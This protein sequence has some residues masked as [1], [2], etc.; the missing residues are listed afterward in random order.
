MNHPFH[1]F[2]LAWRGLRRDGRV[3]QAARSGDGRSRGATAADL[4]RLVLGEG[5]RLAATGAAIGLVAA[6]AGTRLLRALLFEVQ[7]LDPVAPAG[8]AL[9]LAAAAALANYLPARRAARTDPAAMLR[10]D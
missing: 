1:A 5:L 9:L 3:G 6:A 8:A 7:P 4:R 10:A 2:A